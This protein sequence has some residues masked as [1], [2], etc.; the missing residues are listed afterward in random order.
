[1]LAEELTNDVFL[2]FNKYFDKFVES[3]LDEK[4]YLHTIT[5]STI[6][7]YYRNNEYKTRNNFQSIS[8]SNNDDENCKLENTLTDQNKIGTDLMEDDDKK[9]LVNKILN[10]IKNDDIRECVR[11]RYVEE[12]THKEIMEKTGFALDKVKVN[13]H[14]GLILLSENVK[15]KTLREVM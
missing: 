10:S 15:V 7:D 12:L 9:S 5:N 2:K 3:G 8:T 13:L 6:T 11:L 1:M 14:R 4:T